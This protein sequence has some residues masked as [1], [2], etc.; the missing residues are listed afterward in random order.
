MK[1]KELQ[2][3][4][5]KIVIQ[6]PCA[7]NWDEMDGDQT[8][9]FCGQCKKNVHNL[10]AMFPEQLERT[11]ALRESGSLCVFM[12]RRDDGTVIIDNC[13][14]FL[15]KSRDRVRAYAFS[16]ALNLTWMMA[17]SA[18]GQG[19]VGAPAD[20]RYGQAT[21]Y[22]VFPDFGY[23]TARDISRAVTVLSFFLVWF[24][25]PIKSRNTMTA[26]R[27]AIEILGR[28][29]VPILVHLAGMYAINNFGGL[30]GGGI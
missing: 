5:N 20:V 26:R 17:L 3:Q 1:I 8:V 16:A 21:E 9:R 25:F 10:T 18:S 11:L 27:A 22:T 12:A 6:N 24:I 2:D 23:D 30:G 29:A 13:P 7:A 28:I 19:L 4:V 15:R 14:A